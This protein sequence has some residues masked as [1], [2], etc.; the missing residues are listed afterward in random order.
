MVTELLQSGY[1]GFDAKNQ[2][3]K[4]AA[5]LA[6]INGQNTILRELIF[7]QVNVN[8]RDASGVTPLHVSPFQ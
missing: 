2:D 8:F 6:A 5:H 1:P 4:T 7:Y 3:G